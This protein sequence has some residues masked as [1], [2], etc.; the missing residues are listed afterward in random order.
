MKKVMLLAAMLFLVA[1]PGSAN[2]E[3]SPWGLIQTWWSYAAFDSTLI[4]DSTSSDYE[5]ATQTGFGIK[6][7][8]IGLKWKDEALS[9]SIFY[10]ATPGEDNGKAV[11]IDGWVGYQV[12]EQ[13]GIKMGRQPGVCLQTRLESSVKLDM[14]ERPLLSL[15]WDA[16]TGRIAGRDLGANFD[17]KF[18]DQF[19]AGLFL[20][21]GD[22]N[23]NVLLKSSATNDVTDTGAL[24]QIDLGFIAKPMDE[25]KCGATYG[26]PN[27]DRLNMGNMTAFGYYDNGEFFGKLDF[28][29]LMYANEDNSELEYSSMG[30]SF[31]GGYYLNDEWTLVGRFDQWD[32]DT[33]FDVD[34]EAADFPVGFDDHD[35]TYMR[36]LTLGA[37][38]T[39]NP[40]AKWD[41]RLMIN[42]IRKMDEVPD[43]VDVP[44]P[45]LFR[46]M[47]QV[48]LH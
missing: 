12:N 6:R 23:D 19:S 41:Q 2:A 46:I 3:I 1:L 21:N 42:F 18:N 5:S 11:M 48:F 10:Q 20:H 22:K 38:Y 45:N 16:A 27:E 14:M 30:Y 24:P 32:P 9:G 34:S 28:A 40:D 44:D 33:D 35:Y 29:M 17:Y 4:S 36:N 31:T 47:W 26:L 25:F 7:G 15:K 13:L 37:T 8:F 43:D 39:F